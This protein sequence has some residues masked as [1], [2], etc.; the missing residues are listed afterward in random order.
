MWYFTLFLT[1]QC[2]IEFMLSIRFS[3]KWRVLVFFSGCGLVVTDE[4][5]KETSVVGAMY[6]F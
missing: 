5:F 6:V 3:S 1:I 2:V 4:E